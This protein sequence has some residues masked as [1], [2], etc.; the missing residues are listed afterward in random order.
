VILV[1]KYVFLFLFYMLATCSHAC[2]PTST[3]DLNFSHKLYYINNRHLNLNLNFARR[4]E[5]HVCSET[6][7]R[8][9]LSACW[10]HMLAANV[11]LLAVSTYLL[12]RIMVGYAGCWSEV[13]GGMTRTHSEWLEWL[14]CRSGVVGGSS[15]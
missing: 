7:V 15:I 13:R 5:D 6:C 11:G 9:S 2:S 8:G 4:P 3:M 10:L 14:Q 1:R 12:Y